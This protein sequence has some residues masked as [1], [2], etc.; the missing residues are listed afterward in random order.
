M[1]KKQLLEK[2]GNK[3][4]LVIMIYIERCYRKSAVTGKSTLKLRR[5]SVECVTETENSALHRRVTTTTQMG[6]VSVLVYST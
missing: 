5:T 3:S 2:I 4:A 6:M 1:V